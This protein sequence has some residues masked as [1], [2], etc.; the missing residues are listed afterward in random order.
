MGNIFKDDSIL[1]NDYNHGFKIF[2][3]YNMCP[4][5]AFVKF[6]RRDKK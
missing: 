3:I 5:N 6:H 2:K 1:K 4:K